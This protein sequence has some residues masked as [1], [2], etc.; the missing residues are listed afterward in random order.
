[1]WKHM[2]LAASL[3]FFLTIE[4]PYGGQGVAMCLYIL[5][6]R[7]TPVRGQEGDKGHSTIQ[8][9]RP[10]GEGKKYHKKVK[11]TR[12]MWDDKSPSPEVPLEA[13][14]QPT[15]LF[16]P[17]GG[18]P[19][20][21]MQSWRKGSHQGWK[22]ESWKEW[23]CWWGYWATKDFAVRGMQFHFPTTTTSFKITIMQDEDLIL[24]MNAL[25]IA[26]DDGIS[27]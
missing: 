25:S 23:S 17:N 11:A 8:G 27:R 3:L 4:W 13:A 9:L 24:H 21:Y 6:T 14:I 2:F 10:L 7:H 12:I 16:P 22:V 20:L 1:M 19:L 15:L 18:L 5:E 26:P